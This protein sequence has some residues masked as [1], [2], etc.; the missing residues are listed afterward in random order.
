VL[1]F[2]SIESIIVLFTKAIFGY[3]HKNKFGWQLSIFYVCIPKIILGELAHL[4]ERPESI[5][6]G[7]TNDLK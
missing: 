1:F 2:L 4:V 6:E 7:D 3:K 5:R